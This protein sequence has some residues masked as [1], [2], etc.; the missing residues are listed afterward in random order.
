MDINLKEHERLDDLVLDGMKL[1]QRDDQFCFSIDTVLLAHFGKPPH[2]PVLDLGTGTAAIPLILTARG[3]TGLTGI[4][5]NPVMADIARRNVELNQRNHAVR[6]IE[7]DYKKIAS[8]VRTGTFATVYANPP[9]REKFRGACSDTQGIRRARHEETA[10]LDDVMEAAKYALKYHGRFRMIHIIERLTDILESMRKHDI[11]P[12]IIQMIYGHR[13]ANAK[14]FLVEGIRGGNPG[15]EVLPPLII[16]EADGN[17]SRE[18]LR[19][20]GKAAPGEG[21]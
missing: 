21:M 13:H 12:K 15:M 11:E 7:G 18:V 2:Q 8:W 10:T 16:H 1:I 17:Y 4:E 20:Y 19:M 14:I 9:Y 6:I 5:L 3:A